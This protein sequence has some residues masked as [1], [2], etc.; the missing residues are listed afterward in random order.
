LKKIKKFVLY[1]IAIC[2]LFYACKAAL[3]YLYP[4][5]YIDIVKTNCEKYNIDPL[6]IVAVIKAES[7]FDDKATSKKSAKGLMQVRDDTALW[8]AEKMNINLNTEN[9]YDGETNI[10]I[11][12]WYF[13]Y[14]INHFNGNLDVCLAAYNAGMGNVTKWLDNNN[15]SSD[16]V[17]LSHI[18]FGET[19]KYINKV[20]NNYKIYKFLYEKEI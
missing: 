10:K 8:C 12:T 13:D 4:L 11:G 5:K 17:N 15:Y 14:L 7:N 20:K 2:I 9:L 19:K 18:P 3:T 6:L 1:I 16:G